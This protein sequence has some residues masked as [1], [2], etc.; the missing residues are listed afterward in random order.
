MSKFWKNIK[1]GFVMLLIVAL[2]SFIIKKMIY[3]EEYASS[4]EVALRA[5]KSNRSELEKVLHHYQRTPDDSLKY[6]AARYLIEN[7]PFYSYSVGEQLNNYKLYYLW[8]KEGKGKS[9][10]EVADSVKKVFGPIG[11]TIRKRD[12]LEIDSAYLCN[13]IEWAF[14]VW[15]EQPWGK[16]ISFDCF[17]EYIL[18]YRIDDEALAYWREIYYEKYNSLLDSLRI[19]NTLDKED[20]VVA[21]SYLI[22]RLP[23]KEH[24]FTSVTPTAFGHIGPEY[25][26]YLSGSCREVTDFGV[27]LFKA[28]GIPCAIDFIPMSGSGSAGHF[29]LVTW[30]KNGEDYKMD[31]PEPLQLV[32]KSWWYVMD[33]SAKMY[34]YTFSVNRELYESMAIYGEELYPFWRLPKFKDVTHGYAQYYKK[35]MK[36]PSEQIYKEKCDGKIAYLCLSSRDSWIPVDWTEYDRNNLVFRNLKKSSMMRVAT[37]E[38]GS[39]HF[40]TDP[41]I[42]DGWTNKSHYYSAGGEKQDVVLYAKSNIDTENLFRDRMIGGVFEGSNRADFADKDTLFLIQSKPYRLRTVVKSWSDKKYRYLRYV[43][44]EN[45]SCNV[46][47]IAFYEPNDTIALKGKVLGTPGCSQQ[48]GS[49][50]Y[51]NAFDGKTWTS[52]DYI[53]PTGGWTGLDAGK[54][55]QVDR[56]VYTPRNRDN[57]IRPG[58]TFELFY[59]DGDWKSAGMMI[60]TTDS[61]VYRNIP[62]DVLLLLRNHTRGVDERIFVYENGTQAWK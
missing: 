36:I 26:Q 53:E 3:R 29:W 52:F 57:Y 15:Q 50:E 8:L 58:D 37:Y 27:Y 49:H 5:A 61:L 62:K 59:C 32:R 10:E 33:M 9:P 40:V 34:R 11:S 6:K 45:A 43:G 22:E 47:E 1:S 56:I 2:G 14:K 25:V 17:C 30:D 24:I 48:D 54:E 46:A 18:P 19:S 55:V 42:V 41:F 39:L 38:N 60:A 12:I 35:E 13:N 31:F 16:N 51:T 4:L 20:P 23:N 28:L 21:A 7:M 44:P